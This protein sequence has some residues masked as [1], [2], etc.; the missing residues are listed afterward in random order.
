MS[1]RLS[2][3]SD[4]VATF[5]V[6]SA[7]VCSVKNGQAAVGPVCW[8]PVTVLSHRLLAE[9]LSIIVYAVY[10]YIIYIYIIFCIIVS[11]FNHTNKQKESEP[12]MNHDS[13]A[14]ACFAED[15]ENSKILKVKLTLATPRIS[16]RDAWV[17]VCLGGSIWLCVWS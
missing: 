12:Q 4:L 14:V 9:K 16:G 10:I 5:D 6:R 15:A 8:D 11:L 3:I 13:F 17:S 2:Q 1:M 7:M